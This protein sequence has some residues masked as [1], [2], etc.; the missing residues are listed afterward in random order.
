MGIATVDLEENDPNKFQKAKLTQTTQILAQ[1]DEVH[2]SKQA[3]EK[4]ED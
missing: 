2:R 3:E 1:L 4:I